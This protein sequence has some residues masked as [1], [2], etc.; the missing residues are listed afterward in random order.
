MDFSTIGKTL[1]ARN[2]VD[3]LMEDLYKALHSGM[4]NLCQLNGGSPAFFPEV[5]AVWRKSM[6]ELM[7]GDGF[8]NLVGTYAH[9]RGDMRFIKALVTYLND[10]YNWGLTERN[11]AITQGGQMA[12]F[13]LFNVLAGNSDDKRMKEILFPLC[14]DYV[15]YQAQ[16]LAGKSM[17]RG[18]RP[19]IKRIDKHYFKYLIDFDSLDIRP[20]TAA[21]CMS[22]PTNPTGNVVTDDE[23]AQ[24]H[25]IAKKAN[26]PL[27]IDNA[28]GSPLPNICFTEANPIW[29]ENVI[30]SMSLSKIGL[31]G[32]RTGIIIANEAI[33]KAVVSTVT[34]S[35]LCPNNLGQAL[36][37]PALEDG[38]AEK[39]CKEIIT[40]FYYKRSQS[41]QQMLLELMDDDIPWR[42]HKSEGAMFLWLWFE[43]LPISS[44]ELYERCRERGC[45]I[46]SGH[47]FFFALGE[48]ADSWQHT[49][50]C[51][52]ISFTQPL[53]IMRRGI[54]I[55]ADEVR[56]AYRQ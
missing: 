8:D 27:M 26:I 13:I 16:A 24:L 28:Y 38:T 23:L 50:E 6:T 36:I 2:G 47:H 55:I 48:E 4:P 43:G 17:F 41:T 20:E 33:I 56:K 11:I 30:L 51:I 25:D 35:A 44:Q 12:F 52:R 3:D 7:A 22:R 5:S 34:V 21:L 37:T 49:K 1:T 53:D 19:T 29:D 39:M 46:N 18:I 9:P 31:P 40:P 54:E 45:F 32:T 14:P 15:G 42:M 10:K